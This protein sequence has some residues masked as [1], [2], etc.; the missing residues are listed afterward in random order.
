[1]ERKK[2][3]I[4]DNFD[5]DIQEVR[6]GLI[7]AGYEVRVVQNGRDIS[8][9][10]EQFAPDLL[11]IETRLA[12]LDLPE[13][14][15]TV[16]AHEG[17]KVIPVIAASSPTVLDERVN[18]L[19][20]NIDEFLYKP[21]ET[22]EVLARIEI[23]LKEA[24]QAGMQQPKFSP[25]F[26]GSLGEMSLVD[27][28][29]T[30]EVGKK[31]GVIILQRGNAEGQ[32]F[33]TEGEVV[34][35]TL[36]TLDPKQALA[37][38]FT[39]SDGQFSVSMRRHDHA[40]RI[41]VATRELI[42]EGMTRL[43]RWEQLCAQMPSLQSVVLIAPK[44]NGATFTEDEQEVINLLDGKKR[45]I[46]VIEESRFDDLKALRLLKNLYEKGYLIDAPAQESVITEEYLDKYRTH[47]NNG[48][49]T[50][51]V[52][53]GVLATI[54]REPNAA[55]QSYGDRRRNDRRKMDRRRQDRR[56]DSGLP[57]SR[58][59]LNKSELIMVREK[60]LAALKVQDNTENP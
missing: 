21:F 37:R 3:L 25:G 9:Q 39:W 57:D 31:T 22:E 55:V 47:S 12:D 17:E 54:F 26:S 48:A 8:K 4:A 45:F 52:L 16:R 53:A 46:D 38:L 23:L 11:L 20:Q 35:A 59:C 43:Y 42:S 50:G 19:E 49:P 30:L 60:L 1:M 10:L 15:E 36:G 18:I 51:E 7:A 58:I 27:L 40:D 6:R 32:V 24:Q 41:Q 44:K 56:R 2:I 29:Q 34:D 33:V 28:L 14:L 5:F 13:L